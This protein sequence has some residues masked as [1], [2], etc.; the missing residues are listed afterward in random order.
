MK[1]LFLVSI[2]VLLLACGN[3][4]D[5]KKADAATDEKTDI[6]DGE[7][8]SPQLELDSSDTRFEV[9]TLSSRKEAEKESDPEKE[10][11]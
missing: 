2:T 7:E 5:G 6:G 11:F 8:I 1:K 4:T 10:S 3:G 9:D